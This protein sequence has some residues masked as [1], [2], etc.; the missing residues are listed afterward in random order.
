M[1]QSVSAGQNPNANAN[2][3]ANAKVKVKA[4]VDTNGHLKIFAVLPLCTCTLLPT[5]R[6]EAGDSLFLELLPSGH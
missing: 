1:T 6:F 2:A 5:H 4:N 3:N